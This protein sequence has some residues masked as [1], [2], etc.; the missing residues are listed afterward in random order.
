[1]FYWPDFRASERA[2]QVLIQVSGRAGRAEHPGK[3]LIQTYDPHHPVLQVITGKLSEE[4]FLEKERMLR[5]ELCYSPFGRLARLRF[6]SSVNERALEAAKQTADHLK[7]EI[8]SHFFSAYVLGPAQA[9]LKQVKKT[10]RWDIL[11]KAKDRS[12]LQP[13]LEEAILFSKKNNIVFSID[14]DPYAL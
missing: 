7:T 2:L 8:A 14:V 12:V 4:A 6:E 11:L 10:Y 9:F 13:V 5:S 3:V 1:L